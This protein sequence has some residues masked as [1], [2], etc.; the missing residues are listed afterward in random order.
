MLNFN[1]TCKCKYCSK[2]RLHS[3]S[4]SDII[5]IFL[6]CFFS[7]L[8]RVTLTLTLGICWPFFQ[9]QVQGHLLGYLR[10]NRKVLSL[11]LSSVCSYDIQNSVI[12]LEHTAYISLWG[13]K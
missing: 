6:I 5:L 4:I 9:T 2:S 12:S 7:A 13:H 8:V 1:R 11:M 3:L 10:Q